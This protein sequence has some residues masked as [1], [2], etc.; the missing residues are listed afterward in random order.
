MGVFKEEANMLEEIN[1]I[2]RRI[3]NDAADYGFP[4]DEKDPPQQAK[5]VFNIIKELT[6]ADEQYPSDPK[7][8][9]NANKWGSGKNAGKSVDIILF[10]EKDEGYYRGTKY[11]VSFQRMKSKDHSKIVNGDCYLNVTA[12]PFI[13]KAR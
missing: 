13:E 11:T 1:H 6:A 8:I 9:R 7:F 5:N 12:K 4:F 2:S 3:Y 10:W